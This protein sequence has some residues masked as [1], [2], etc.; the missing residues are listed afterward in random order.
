MVEVI[1]TE[2]FEAWFLGLDDQ[3]AKAVDLVVGLL[4][5]RGVHLGFPHSSAINNA[6]FAKAELSSTN[7]IP[8][9]VRRTSFA[10][11]PTR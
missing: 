2:E 8:G 9:W 11:R 6:S 3:A 5:A 10:H 7:S 4:E 1:G